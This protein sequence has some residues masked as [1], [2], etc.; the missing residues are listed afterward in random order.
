M[1][2][3]ALWASQPGKYFVLATKSGSGAWKEYFFERAQFNKVPVF[4]REHSDRDIYFCVHG[5][6]KPERLKKFA[7][8]PE[9]LWADLDEVNPREIKPKPT[10]AIESSPGRYV[11]I[12]RV[13]QTIEESINQRLTYH[14]GADRGGWDLTQVLRVPNTYNYKYASTPKVK[15][16]WDDGPTW[17][18]DRIERLLPKKA[19]PV[20]GDPAKIMAKYNGALTPFVRR[21]LLKGKPTQG[22]RSEVL[23]K[24]EHELL[25]AGMSKEEALIVLKASPWNK[26]KGRMSEDD[27]LSREL[28][29]VYSGLLKAPPDNKKNGYNFLAQSMAEVEEAN[30]DWL[31][32]PYLARGEVTIVEG[33]PEAGKSFVTQMVGKHI[34]DGIKLPSAK[35]LKTMKGPVAYFDT[36]N[37][38]ATVTKKRL[39]HNNCQNMELFFQEEEPFTMDDEDS[40]QHMFEAIERLKPV[41]V[42]FDTISLYIGSA[43]TGIASQTTQALAVFKEIAKRYNCAVVIIRHLTKERKNNSSKALYRGQGSIAFAGVA[44]IVLTVGYDPEDADMRVLTVTKNNLARRPRALLFSLTGLPDTLKRQDACVFKWEGFADYTSDEILS[45]HK[46]VRGEQTETAETFLKETLGDG[47]MPLDKLIVMADKRAISKTTLHR[48]AEKLGVHKHLSGFGKDKVS[49]WKL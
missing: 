43:D 30:I 14:L 13:D 46:P 21:E 18:L 37:S 20:I 49:V 8:M 47:E 15:L 11:G 16:L 36:E 24:I 41:M 12:W 17:K 26:F 19:D 34:V 27:Q 4:I 5:F 39:L 22:K 23:W 2:I 31:W 6:T 42:V 1:I 3:T 10:I 48:A 28:D 9:L 40:R 25:Q 33:D 35:P 45:V 29:K 38:A 7:V 44:R 32:F